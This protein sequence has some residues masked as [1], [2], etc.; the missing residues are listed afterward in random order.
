MAM[1]SDHPPT[2]NATAPQNNPAATQGNEPGEDTCMQSPNST[3]D[4]Y[5]VGE[6]EDAADSDDGYINTLDPA[7]YGYNLDESDSESDTSMALEDWTWGGDHNGPMDGNEQTL[8]ENGNTSERRSKPCKPRRV[9]PNA[10]WYPFPDL[11]VCNIHY[12]MIDRRMEFR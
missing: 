4:L 1:T 6:E 9:P 5:Y 11:E 2:D 10:P 3:I 8:P 12:C 7:E